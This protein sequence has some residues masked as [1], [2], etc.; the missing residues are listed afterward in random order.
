MRHL[1]FCLVI[2]SLLTTPAIAANYFTG[3]ERDAALAAVELL[4]PIQARSQA[5]ILSVPG[6]FGLGIGLDRTTGRF[7]FQAFVDKSKPLPTLPP[8][9]EGVPLRVVRD[10]PPVAVDGGSACMP[11]HANQ[12]VLPVE[13]GNS[14]RPVAAGSSC[15]SCTMGFKACEPQTGNTVWVTAAHC[16]TD[17]TLC[18]GTAPVGTA[19]YHSSPGDAFFQCNLTTNVGSV[20]LQAPPVPNGTVDAVSVV[21]DVS[22]TFPSVR[23]IGGLAVTTGTPLLG[24]DV[25]KSGRTT[26]KTTGSVDAT[27]TAVMISYNC[28]AITL[29][30]QVRIVDT[31]GDIFCTG[32]DSGSGVFDMGSPAQVVGL[33]VARNA[34]GTTCWANTASNVL[35]ALGA[36]R[37]IAEKRL[38]HTNHSGVFES[39]YPSCSG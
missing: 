37:R 4:K 10:T 7:V 30:Q 39:H 33:L 15:G 3:A 34:A 29:N 17:A 26:G 13:M 32:G 18:P 8:A 5:K 19:S 20:S 36:C 9:L 11:C 27:N 6:V 28:G 31:T 35:S 1:R 14:G 21:S 23:D 2:L 25:Q 24:D 38:L 12:L 22:L 16:A